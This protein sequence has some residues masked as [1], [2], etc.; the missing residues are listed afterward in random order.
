MI[1]NIEI[2]RREECDM[3]L[4]GIL[5]RNLSTVERIIYNTISQHNPNKKKSEIM[6]IL[7]AYEAD[8]EWNGPVML[9]GCSIEE[10]EKWLVKHDLA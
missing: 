7:D 9:T 2:L 8:Q 3:A 6:T 4:F 1:L 5:G 10:V